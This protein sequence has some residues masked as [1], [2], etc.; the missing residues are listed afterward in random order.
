MQPLSQHRAFCRKFEFYFTLPACQ[1]TGCWLQSCTFY[2]FL[3]AEN[4]KP[5]LGDDED[6]GISSGHSKLD[7]QRGKLGRRDRRKNGRQKTV[8]TRDR[9][10]KKKNGLGGHG[11]S[12]KREKFLSPVNYIVFIIFVLNM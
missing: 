9:R 6:E 11:D 3:L 10:K 8:Q 4:L 1:A 12:E 5:S 7:D 2:C